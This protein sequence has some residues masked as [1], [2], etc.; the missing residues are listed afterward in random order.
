[1]N[2][3]FKDLFVCKVLLHV[4]TNNK[5]KNLKSYFLA[6]NT[7]VGIEFLEGKLI[8]IAVSVSKTRLERERFVSAK[9]K[10][11]Q[12]RKTSRSPWRGYTHETGNKVIT[13]SKLC[14]ISPEYKPPEKKTSKELFTEVESTKEKDGTWNFEILIYYLNRRNIG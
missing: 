14:T 1:M 3:K 11:S 9:D 7:P 12:K 10:I 6:A 13:L 4:F 5:K 2:C 8:D